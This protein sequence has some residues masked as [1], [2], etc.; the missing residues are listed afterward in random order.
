MNQE[1]RQRLIDKILE[2]N[3]DETLFNLLKLDLQDIFI[4][5]LESKTD[6]ELLEI[7]L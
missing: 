7:I 3:D 4:K 6:S 2:E 5:A 1:L